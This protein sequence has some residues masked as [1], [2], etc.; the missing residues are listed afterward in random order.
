MGIWNQ[1]MLI[2]GEETCE[3][4]L[5]EKIGKGRIARKVVI[6]NGKIVDKPTDVDILGEETPDGFIISGIKINRKRR[7]RNEN[8]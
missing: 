1:T 6:K 4:K 8:K 7:I 2:K 3:I 5:E